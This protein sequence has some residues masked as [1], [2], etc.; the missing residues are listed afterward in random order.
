MNLEFR[1]FNI[2]DDKI[3][4]TKEEKR[5]KIIY[6][7]ELNDQDEFEFEANTPSYKTILPHIVPIITSYKIKKEEKKLLG[8]VSDLY[9]WYYS[10]VENVNTEAPSKE[11][12]DLTN[13]ITAD[14]KTDLEKV[15]AIYYWT[16][17]NIKKISGIRLYKIGIKICL[18]TTARSY[19]KRHSY[20]SFCPT[21]K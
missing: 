1:K 4:F 10:L 5:R 14:K 8:E 3:K 19:G 2:S 20:S 16:Q 18:P 7:W 15:K 11:L 17:K 21:T 13:K 6:S 12:I 9:G